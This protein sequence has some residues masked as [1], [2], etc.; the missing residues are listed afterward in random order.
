[1]AVAVIQH[2]EKAGAE[3]IGPG[4]AGVGIPPGRHVPQHPQ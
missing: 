2:F 1:M 4:A 3:T